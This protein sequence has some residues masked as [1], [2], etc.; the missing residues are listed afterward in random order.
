MRSVRVCERRWCRGVSNILYHGVQGGVSMLNAISVDNFAARWQ[1]PSVSH[2]A[3]PESHIT[4]TITQVCACQPP[5]RHPASKSHLLNTTYSVSPRGAARTAG[6]PCRST[7]GTC[8]GCTPCWRRHCTT[9]SASSTP[10]VFQ[11]QGLAWTT[12]SQRVPSHPA[13]P[14]PCC[15]GWSGRGTPRPTSFQAVDATREAKRVP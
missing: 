9:Y 15:P 5:P 12:P 2:R 4:H 10:R 14:S 3:A 7:C 8:S 13:S 6:R 1:W 11:M